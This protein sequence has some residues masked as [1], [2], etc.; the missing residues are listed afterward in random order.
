MFIPPITVAKSDFFAAPG[1]ERSK[2]PLFWGAWKG[3]LLSEFKA[4]M[5]SMASYSSNINEFFEGVSGGG[6]GS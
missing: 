3:E 1:A 2:S 6:V 5:A 4:D